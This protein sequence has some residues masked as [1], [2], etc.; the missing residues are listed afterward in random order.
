MALKYPPSPE[1]F[2]TNMKALKHKFYYGN[3]GKGDPEVCHMEM[4]DYILRVM[5]SLGYK[6]GVQIFRT[7]PKW[8]A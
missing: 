5:E 4:D 8:Y 2:E 6:A 3:P 1:E 7:T